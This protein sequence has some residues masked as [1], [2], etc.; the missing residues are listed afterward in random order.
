LL[1]SVDRQLD[2]F[3]GR[4]LDADQRLSVPDLMDEVFQKLPSIVGP[5]NPA[6]SSGFITFG[7]GPISLSTLSTISP[8]STPLSLEAITVLGVTLGLEYSDNDSR[9]HFRPPGH[10]A[11]HFAPKRSCG[12]ALNSGG[13]AK[14]ALSL[15]DEA[16]QQHPA[17]RNI[18]TALVSIARDQADFAAA[19]RH[20]RDLLALDPGNTQL[21][22]LISELEQRH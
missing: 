21:R 1:E 17:D 19:L 10:P 13:S 15:L 4:G 14:E 5:R 6:S 8:T 3:I 11:T 20:A 7:I 2:P 16:H 18:L 22:A 9:R 12:D